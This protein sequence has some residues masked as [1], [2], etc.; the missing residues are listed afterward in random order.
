MKLHF[1]C[2]LAIDRLLG[3][4]AALYLQLCLERTVVCVQLIE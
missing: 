4:K 1:E 2:N 3:G